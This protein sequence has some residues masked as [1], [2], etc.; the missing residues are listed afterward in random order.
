MAVRDKLPFIPKRRNSIHIGDDRWRSESV[1]DSD[2]QQQKEKSHYLEM[3]IQVNA[4]EN[5]VRATNGISTIYQPCCH[6]TTS[7]ATPLAS[8][9]VSGTLGTRRTKK[10]AY[11]ASLGKQFDHPSDGSMTAKNTVHSAVLPGSA[12]V[13]T[14]PTFQIKTQSRP[15]TRGD[16]KD[17][18]VPTLKDKAA[19]RVRGKRRK[20][21]SDL[22]QKFQPLP[23]IDECGSPD[24]LCTQSLHERSGGKTPLS[25]R[26]RRKLRFSN[27]GKEGDQDGISFKCSLKTSIDAALGLLDEGNLASDQEDSPDPHR[28]DHNRCPSL[29]SLSMP[30]SYDNINKKKILPSIKRPADGEMSPKFSPPHHQGD[31]ALSPVPFLRQHPFE[32]LF[33]QGRCGPHPCDADD[34]E[35]FG[36]PPKASSRDLVVDQLPKIPC[37]PKSPGALVSMSRST[38]FV[39]TASS[40]DATSTGMQLP[41]QCPFSPPLVA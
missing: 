34:T 23:T 22:K 3:E 5:D 8:A 28:H 17:H 13:T 30:V 15:K 21:F 6:P 37:R 10:A 14:D 2:V 7:L 41:L 35:R 20:S 32:L 1:G 38:K 9:L 16:E 12:D 40:A 27:C 33:Q 29:L 11:L 26:I 24:S 25:Y 36:L 39:G 31:A 18:H 19:P 4:Y